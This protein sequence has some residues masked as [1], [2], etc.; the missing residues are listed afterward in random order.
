MLFSLLKH[1]LDLYTTNTFCSESLRI[2]LCFT[3]ISHGVKNC[4]ARLW[5]TGISDAVFIFLG[6]DIRPMWPLCQRKYHYVV[7]MCSIDIALTK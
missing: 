5:G 1:C 2:F 4:F 3:S 7:E 6:S